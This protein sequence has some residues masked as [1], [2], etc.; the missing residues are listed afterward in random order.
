MIVAYAGATES[1]EKLTAI[2]AVDAKNSIVFKR[3][4]NNS[5][6][7]Q[8]TDP[9]SRS[10]RQRAR[11]GSTACVTSHGYVRLE[12]SPVNEKGSLQINSLHA[13]S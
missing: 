12:D 2:K 1:G 4:I 9:L 3:F 7:N 6:R 5:S 11:S 10:T 13:S 8:R